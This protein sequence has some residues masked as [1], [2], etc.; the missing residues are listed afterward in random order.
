MYAEIQ[1]ASF[2]QRVAA[3]FLDLILLAVVT[4]GMM[5][6]MSAIVDYD[7][8]STIVNDAYTYYEEQYGVD[9]EITQEAY[10]ALSEAERAKLDEA[11]AALIADEEAQQ[12]YNMTVNLI[13]LMTTVSI[14][15][16]MLLLHLVVPLL[17]KNGRTLGKKVFA[18]GVIRNDG[19]KMNNLQLFVRTLL[20]RFTI[21]TMI[22]VYIILMILWGRIG[23]SGPAL[24]LA[25]LLAQ[26]ICMFFN[27]NNAAI[28]DLMAGTVVVDLSMQKVFESSEELLEYT[29]NEHAERAARQD[30]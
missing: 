24:L 1:K 23:I 14:F 3:W 12:A 29:Q 28:H 30:Y 16:S 4:T 27:R 7:K 8:H 18:L 5:F 15:V 2:W 25:L 20:G 22:P 17:L 13:L 11:Y 21:E 10:D 19:V 6:L 26:A 9:F